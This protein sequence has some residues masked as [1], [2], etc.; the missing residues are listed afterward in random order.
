[1][2]SFLPRRA[3]G[4]VA[5]ALVLSALLSMTISAHAADEFPVT[6]AQMQGL[7][8]T[9]QRLEKPADRW[10]VT[11]VRQLHFE[12]AEHL[13]KVLLGT[14]EA[15]RWPGPFSPPSLYPEEKGES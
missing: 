14:I 4:R 8:I 15:V 1:M 2:R 10:E 13:Q 5:P 11:D 3:L 6:P 12:W 9:L 7:G